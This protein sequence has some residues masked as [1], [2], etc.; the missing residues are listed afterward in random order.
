MDVLPL[1]EDVWG[2]TRL[3]ASQKKSTVNI[4]YGQLARRGDG[5]PAARA[6]RPSYVKETS[7]ARDGSRLGGFKATS[8]G[9]EVGWHDGLAESILLAAE[10]TRLMISSG[11]NTS[12]STLHRA[13]GALQLP[14]DHELH[15]R[16]NKLNHAYTSL[17]H[18]DAIGIDEIMKDVQAVLIKRSSSD[19]PDAAILAYG[20]K[21]SVGP[22]ATED[23]ETCSLEFHGDDGDECSIDLSSIHFDSFNDGSC[24]EVQTDALD[25]W[26]AETPVKAVLN[27][28]D[29]PSFGL[30]E[31]LAALVKLDGGS[32]PPG[33]HATAGDPI[34]VS[35][36]MES[37]L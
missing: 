29:D 5:N 25:T 28:H 9:P 31:D 1:V 10:K 19:E 3:N 17:H 14:T 12:C 4:I 35:S 2:S 26:F 20:E 18:A 23:D 6:Y 36:S 7:A 32:S 22:S 37:T 30:C 8:D 13:I 34:Q 27:H 16:L 33:G 11:T 15:K 24:F 21:S